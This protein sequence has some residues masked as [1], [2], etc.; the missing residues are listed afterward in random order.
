MDDYPNHLAL[1][2]AEKSIFDPDAQ[3][4]FVRFK[5]WW[6]RVGSAAF[7]NVPE[8][9][10]Q[11]WLW[12]HWGNSDWSSLPSETAR[13]EEQIWQPDEVA[14]LHFGGVTEDDYEPWE[15]GERLLKPPPGA[16]LIWL[17]QHMNETKRWP[18]PPIVLDNRNLVAEAQ[19]VDFDVPQGFVVVEGHRRVQ[20]A[21][22]LIRRG[23]LA[24]DL[25]IWVLSYPQLF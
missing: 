11:H 14:D 8:N 10:A 20:I 4:Q 6:D 18:E 2:E 3:E 9:V 16:P 22:A 15:N 25:P 24:G 12:R 5:A 17:A 19:L 7:P 21:M 1:L 13:F 23:E